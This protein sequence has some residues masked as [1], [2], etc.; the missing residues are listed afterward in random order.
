MM[1]ITHSHLRESVRSFTITPPCTY[2]L[3]LFLNTTVTNVKM[4]C[5]KTI[6]MA[7]LLN[8]KRERE[9]EEVEEERKEGKK[10][11]KEK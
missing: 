2:V 6:I 11:R 9:D 5:I 1:L 4:H 10:G 3:M 8:K 7:A